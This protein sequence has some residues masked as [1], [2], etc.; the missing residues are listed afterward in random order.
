M[1][2]KTSINIFALLAVAVIGAALL[3]VALQRMAIDT[4]IVRSLPTDDPV[5][6]DGIHIFE[7]NPIKDQIAIDIGCAATDVARLLAAA[8]MV[9]TRLD[10]KRPVR[11]GGQPNHA[12]GPGRFGGS[13]RP[14]PAG[15]L[16]RRGAAAT[17][18]PPVD[19]RGH[20]A[21]PD[22]GPG[23]SL[24]DGRH[25]A[26][27]DHGRRSAGT[28]PHRPGPAGRPEPRS[29]GNHSPRPDSLR[30]PAPSAGPGHPVRFGHGYDRGPVPDPFFPGP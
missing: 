10:A 19:R 20:P 14:A 27:I 6:A 12:A 26:G 11:A 30:R 4:D 29:R 5:I 3:L 22:P 25:R 8:E 24:P 15:S 16:H 28:A 2:L 21:R 17:G 9:E 1:R 7:K 23:R 13:G 18:G